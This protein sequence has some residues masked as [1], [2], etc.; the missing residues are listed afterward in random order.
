M[1]IYVNNWFNFTN[2]IVTAG[3]KNCANANYDFFTQT[4]SCVAPPGTGTNVVVNLYEDTTLIASS[5]FNYSGNTL[6][7]PF[8]L[9][10]APYIT[11][12][13]PSCS[14]GSAILISGYYF[15]NDK[16]QISVTVDDQP[17]TSVEIYA[18]HQKIL[19]QAPSAPTGSNLTLLVTVNGQSSINTGFVYYYETHVD[20]RTLH[21]Y[22]LVNYGL[23]WNV[24]NMI[25]THSYL[26]G[27]QGYLATVTSQL[28][29]DF[30]FATFPNIERM[31]VWSERGKRLIEIGRVI[32]SIPRRNMGLG[33]T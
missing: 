22:C 19:C 9:Y 10:I 16:D 21:Y 27:M 33:R 1:Y 7:L 18:D 23:T 15:G 29:N 14:L 28:E 13:T 25:A 31:Q 3:G 24:T 26:N 17:C 4:I 30:I 11:S 5:T 12:V 2:L 32:G 20:P 6:F 8:H